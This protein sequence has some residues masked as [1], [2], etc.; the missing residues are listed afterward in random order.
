MLSDRRRFRQ[1][2]LILA[3]AFAV[4]SLA[5]T[6]GWGWIPALIV[7]VMVAA[8]LLVD[9]IPDVVLL[10]GVTI[11]TVVAEAT[12]G[13][14]TGYFVV[15]TVLG[16]VASAPTGWPER[17]VEAA[18]IA[19]PFGLWVA[20]VPDYLEFGFWTW[21]A[22][23]F[24]G[25]LFGTV[26]GRLAQAVEELQASRRQL[27]ESSAR[28]ERHRIARELHDLV[29]HS[30]SVVLLHLA[31]ART[32][33]DRDPERARKALAEAEEVGRRGMN[34]LREALALMRSDAVPREPVAGLDQLNGLIERYR[35]AGL[36]VETDVDPTVA[37]HPDGVGAAVGLVVHDVVR[38]ALTNAAKHA[39][40]KP[41][42]VAIK[43]TDRV[44]V[45]V[46]NPV[47]H[48]SGRAAVSTRPGVGLAGLRERVESIGGSFEAGCRA[49]H[50]RVAADFPCRADQAGSRPGD[51]PV[52]A[53]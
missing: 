6:T 7:G 10:A 45:A 38:E 47:D 8:A 21:S 49:D 19:S 48:P 24:M 1:A 35:S 36:A 41:V 3:L 53:S 37:E 32:T 11:A 15:I 2:A 20:R 42:T 4:L 43:A 9:A 5:T 33:L 39:P 30:F 27:A 26:T 28:D 29:G 44:S 13:A 34:D 18:A 52:V 50:W 14:N 40:T 16:I 12:D 46:T 31:G 17:V 25:W 51:A 23:L 22:G